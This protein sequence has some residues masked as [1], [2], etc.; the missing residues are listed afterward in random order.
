MYFFLHKYLQKKS[1]GG[2]LGGAYKQVNLQE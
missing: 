1:A 2:D